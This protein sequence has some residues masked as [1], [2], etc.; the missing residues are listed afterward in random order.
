[1]DWKELI[2]V[3]GKGGTGKSTIAATLARHLTQQGRRVLLVELDQKSSVRALLGR[4]SGPRYQPMGSGLGFDWSLVTGQDCLVE[5]V[6]SFTRVESLTQKFFDSPLLRTLVN[7]APGLN[8]LSILG[9]LTSR[10]RGHGPPFD[11]DH[12]VVDAPSTG[13][14]LS[15][16]QA[17]LTL[18]QTVSRG[19]LHTQSLDIDRILK[20]PEVC[21]FFFVS[22]F[23]ELPVDELEDTL[24]NFSDQYKDQ[25]HV[26]MNK[27]LV[28]SQSS[29]AAGP[30]RHFIENKLHEQERQ[31]VRVHD[32][33]PQAYQV[34]L[35]TEGFRDFLQ[36][37]Q[38]EV[39][40]KI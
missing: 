5:Y 24:A 35:F 16:V 11:Y 14:F 8:D 20:D 30:W 9:K 15:L 25:I 39:L 22:L 2:F 1:L 13:S 7:V 10:V 23:E 4:Q 31:R 27:S 40:R 26:I 18:G 29:A 12:V 17:P 33:W 37:T 28:L 19:P 21:Q 36:Q 34:P 38:R 32:L 6:S 3:S